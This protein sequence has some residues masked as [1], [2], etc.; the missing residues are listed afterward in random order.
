MGGGR[1]RLG[2]AGGEVGSQAY[3]GDSL[4]AHLSQ[5]PDGLIDRPGAIVHGGKKVGV[6]VD[7]ASVRE[8]TRM[9]MASS[10]SL[11]GA[12]SACANN[13]SVIKASAARRSR[14][15]ERSP[16]WERARSRAAWLAATRL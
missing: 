9:E 12:V 5:Y 3:I 4:P 7:H 1:A 13:A 16:G 11:S 10:S 2:S 6:Q 15:P 8:E 14:A